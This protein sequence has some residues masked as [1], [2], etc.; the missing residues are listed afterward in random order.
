MWVSQLFTVFLV[1]FSVRSVSLLVSI[2]F[3]RLPYEITYHVSECVVFNSVFLIAMSR[4]LA[5]L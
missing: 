3:G 1:F 5:M 4:C 2:C